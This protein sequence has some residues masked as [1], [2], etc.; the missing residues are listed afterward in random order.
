MW[1]LAIL[2]LISHLWI[3][4]L[5]LLQYVKCCFMMEWAG[6]KLVVTSHSQKF[7]SVGLFLFS[8]HPQRETV[9]FLTYFLA[10]SCCLLSDVKIKQYNHKSEW[11]DELQL[12][13]IKFLPHNKLSQSL[14]K[15]KRHSTYNKTS[16]CRYTQSQVCYC[17]QK[18]LL[19]RSFI[20]MCAFWQRQWRRT[21]CRL[22]RGGISWN[23][24]L[25]KLRRN[26]PIYAN[27]YDVFKFFLISCLSVNYTHVCL[28]ASRKLCPHPVINYAAN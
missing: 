6:L 10:L 18:L 1:C 9:G 24:C 19:L 28:K 27:R 5:I 15:R 3:L 17:Y 23:S 21:E 7:L 22:K 11:K 8:G 4:S 25:S 26:W 12:N 13:D 16:L 2:P 20:G 14:E